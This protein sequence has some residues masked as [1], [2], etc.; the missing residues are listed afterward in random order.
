MT[1]EIKI[2]SCTNC[3]SQYQK[4]LGQCPNCGEWGTVVEE[5]TMVDTKIKDVKYEIKKLGEIEKQEIRRISS[6]FEE[7]DRVLGQSIDAKTTG[8]LKGQVLL[9]SGEPGVGKSTI[10][11]QLVANMQKAGLNSL[12]IT[13]EESESQIASRAER[14]LDKEILS[15]IQ[16]LS[17]FNID[18]VIRFIENRKIDFLVLDSI[19]TVYSETSTSFPGSVSQVKQC[20]GKLIT[21]AK[22]NGVTLVIVGHINKEGMIAG[23]KILEH[24]VDTVFQ[25]E[26]DEKTGIRFLRSLKNRFGPTMEVGMFTIEDVG[27]KDLSDPSLYLVTERSRDLVGVCKSVIVE[28]VRPVLIEV[29]ALTNQTSFSL[30]RRVSEGFSNSRLQRILAILSK[31]LKISFFEMDVFVKIAGGIRVMDP[32]IDLAIALALVSSAQNRKINPNLI[33]FGELDLT[34]HISRITRKKDRI[35]EAQRLGYR[36]IFDDDKIDIKKMITSLI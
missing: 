30:P 34:G 36:E 24:L 9:L 13:S 7:F 31:Y 23:P 12:Y 33:A 26:G 32:A 2:F 11:L 28:G 29:Q 8:F 35:K 25:L 19:Q 20:A 18:S 6:G 22:Q 16:V 17:A 21:F 3:G 27:M 15:G 5:I 14:I 10:L 1:K 4:W